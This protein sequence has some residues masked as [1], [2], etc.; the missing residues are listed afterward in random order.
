MSKLLNLGRKE[1]GDK[2]RASDAEATSADEEEAF[3]RRA[4]LKQGGEVGG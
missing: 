4:T 3:Q 1:D 2:K